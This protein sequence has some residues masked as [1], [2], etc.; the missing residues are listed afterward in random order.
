[1]VMIQDFNTVLVEVWY[2]N[3]T[4]FQLF[5]MFMWHYGNDLVFLRRYTVKQHYGNEEVANNVLLQCGCAMY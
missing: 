3:N 4:D 5:N 2:A 1:M